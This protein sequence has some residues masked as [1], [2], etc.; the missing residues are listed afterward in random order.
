MTALLCCCI[1]AVF[2]SYDVRDEL[3]MPRTHRTTVTGFKT[4]HIIAAPVQM[5]RGHPGS[6][7]NPYPSGGNPRRPSPRG[8]GHFTLDNLDDDEAIKTKGQR[9]NKKMRV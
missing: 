7:S 3:V 2:Q 8:G 4:A 1:L 9:L 6:T 5:L